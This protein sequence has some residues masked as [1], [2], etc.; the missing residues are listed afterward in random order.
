VRR[1]SRSASARRRWLLSA[2]SPGLSARSCRKQVQPLGVGDL[3]SAHTGTSR[4]ETATGPPKVLICSLGP[5]EQVEKPKRAMRRR[6]ARRQ[7]IRPGKESAGIRAKF[8]KSTR[9]VP[10][11]RAGASSAFGTT[12]VMRRISAHGAT[13]GSNWALSRDDAKH[14]K[15][16]PGRCFEESLVAL[17]PPALLR[18]VDPT[19]EREDLCWL[20][21]C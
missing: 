14:V 18:S 7:R 16:R 9:A 17:L 8:P 19:R 10:A 3:R 21:P 20:Q 4:V 5:S 1:E 2:D 13:R 6:P 11:R 12:M 15:G